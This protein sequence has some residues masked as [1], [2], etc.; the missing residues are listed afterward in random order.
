MD[1]VALTMIVRNESRVIERCLRSARPLIDSYV[2]CDTGSTDDTIE[3]I[4]EVLTDIPGVVH[5]RPWVDFGHNRTELAE[6]ARGTARFHLLL[7]ADMTI[8][9]NGDLP[10]LEPAVAYL[11]RHRGEVDYLSHR[12][13]DG[14]HPWR[15][16]GAAHERLDSPFPF[17]DELLEC[18]SVVHHDD[19]ADAGMPRLVRDRELM[20]R[21]F[22]EHPDDPRTIFYFGLVTL[23]GRD[24]DLARNLLTRRVEMTSGRQ[25]ERY[26]AA[27]K[28]IRIALATGG[29]AVAAAR[30][31]IGIDETRA[32]G[33]IDLARALKRS[34]DNWSA[35]EAARRAA[36]CEVPAV[37]SFVEPGA[38]TW[39]ADMEIAH[40]AFVSG[41]ADEAVAAATRVLDSPESPTRF[42]KLAHEL[43]D[44]AWLQSGEPGRH[45]KST[46]RPPSPALLEPISVWRIEPQCTPRWRV[47]NPSIV[48]QGDGW[49]ISTRLS[50]VGWTGTSFEIGDQTGKFRSLN[51]LVELNSDLNVVDARDSRSGSHPQTDTFQLLRNGRPAVDGGGGQDL[52]RGIIA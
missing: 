25:D 48:R 46:P 2:I 41:Q 24:W 11:T 52:G 9:I 3:R 14:T 36:T 34:G 26:Y 18:L 10:R 12:L 45:A 6:L 17:H 15:W 33:W 8:S 49:I 21:E 5:E 39:R 37:A 35:L 29:D 1:R 20:G 38:S 13:I 7:D 44:V 28:L 32:E 23:K 19:G 50:N 30:R 31:A 42:R 40:C 16:V 47:T 27:V 4:N 22:R 51:A 43:G